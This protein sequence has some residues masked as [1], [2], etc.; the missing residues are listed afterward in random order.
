MPVLSRTPAILTKTLTYV[1]MAVFIF[2]LDIITGP[3]LQF[4][5]LFVIPV[6]MAAWYCSAPT[7]YV[8][9]L[10]LP[11]GRL[12]IALIIEALMPVGFAEINALIRIAVLLIIAYWIRRSARQ[13][14][15]LKARVSGLVTICAWSK[16]VEYEG[17]WIS[18]EEYLKRRFQ[19]NTSHGISPEEAKRVLDEF[20]CEQGEHADDS[21]KQAA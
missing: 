16:T 17:A 9:A 2:V 1:V 4:P 19:L 11:L 12:A 10:L 6:G 18:F 3:Y 14:R 13:T 5:I 7:A 8:L 21:G 15:E 20:K